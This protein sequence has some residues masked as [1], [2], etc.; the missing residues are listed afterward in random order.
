MSNF[1]SEVHPS[2]SSIGRIY[3]PCAKK[4]NRSYTHT[5]IHTWWEERA[6]RLQLEWDR[7]ILRPLSD[8]SLKVRLFWSCLHNKRE[9]PAQF[10]ACACHYSAILALTCKWTC[11]CSDP[12]IVMT[13]YLDHPGN[14]QTP[15][16]IHEV[17]SMRVASFPSGAYVSYSLPGLLDWFQMSLHVCGR[18]PP[19]PACV[20]V[21]LG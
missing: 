10:S 14:L 7:Q 15:L 2:F 18:L 8:V 5:Y 12:T 19:G 11:H 3:K 21:N 16:N 13:M 4:H 1:F 17:S 6:K 9:D 20:S